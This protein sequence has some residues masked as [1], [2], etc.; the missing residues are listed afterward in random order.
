[1]IKILKVLGKQDEKE[2]SFI[3]EDS[4]KSYCNT[5]QKEVK[6]N[7]FDNKLSTISTPLRDVVKKMLTFNPNE[8]QSA[9]NLLEHTAFNSIRNKNQEVNA[10]TTVKLPFDAQGMYDY[11]NFED[12]ISL[13]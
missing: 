6:E 4:V 7:T 10:C 12:K 5:I 2:M 1:M 13:S 8:R 11:D 3:L 9:E